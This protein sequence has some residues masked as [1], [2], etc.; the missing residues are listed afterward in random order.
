MGRIA[1]GSIWVKRNGDGSVKVDRARRPL[2]YARVTFTD[3]TGRRRDIK[4]RALSRGDA[5][6]II[7]AL[8]GEIEREGTRALDAERMSFAALAR[9]YEDTYVR[10]AE[11]VDGR[12]VAGLRQPDR[13]RVRLQVL[14]A[15]FG[16]KRI[17][18]IRPSEIEAFKLERLREPTRFDHLRFAQMRKAEPEATLGHTRAVASVNRELALLRRVFNV[19]IAEGWLRRNPCNLSRTLI[20]IADE[21]RRTRTLSRHEEEKLLDACSQ[22]H[23]KTRRQYLVHL[24]P[25][26]I[27]ALDTGMR[28]GELIKMRWRD[29]DFDR[30]IIT[31]QAFNTKT[32]TERSV[33][34]TKRAAAALLELK[35]AAASQ[36]ALVF[37]ITDSIKRSWGTLR[38][39]VG[40]T[41]VK[42][43]DLRHTTATRLARAGL[44]MAELARLLGHADLQ[45][46]LR[47]VNPDMSLPVRAARLLES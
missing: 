34:L 45:T 44:P 33:G 41:D 27:L 21:R 7:R 25:I 12:K 39:S 16:H 37:G 11:Y 29:I 10:E 2:I 6:R 28:H 26:I 38:A 35:R 31:V 46:T 4:R 23:I 43:H 15:R 17:Q 14:V 47:Y 3:S 5:Q 22:Y 8:L 30:E 9:Y 40:L 24:R 13:Y 19:A 18:E 1:T 32:Q 36:D 42:F 20:S